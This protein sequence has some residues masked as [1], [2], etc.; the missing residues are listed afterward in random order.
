MAAAA[1]RFSYHKLKRER[2]CP[3][4]GYE[5]DRD[6]QGSALRA[7]AWS[8]LRRVPVRRRFRVGA[9]GARVRRYL[10]SRRVLRSVRASWERVV[11]RVRDGQAHFGDLF[12]GNYMFLQVN[13]TPFPKLV[14]GPCKA[15]ADDS[16]STMS[17]LITRP[18]V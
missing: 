14:Q 12:A 10:R 11:R 7:R 17:Y 3:P 13:P 9:L 18:V 1:G 4:T 16:R 8:R 6:D 5:D 15:R 2:D